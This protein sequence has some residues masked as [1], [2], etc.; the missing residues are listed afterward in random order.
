MHVCHR[1]RCVWLWIGSH[2]RAP[3]WDLFIP[4]SSLEEVWE[5]PIYILAG[6]DGISFVP[7][8]RQ[9]TL[10]ESNHRRA[11]SGPVIFSARTS[12]PF[13][14]S[15]ASEWGSERA[16]EG[17]REKGREGGEVNIQGTRGAADGVSP[18]RSLASN[19]KEQF[20]C[21]AEMLAAPSIPL[22]LRPNKSVLSFSWRCRQIKT[23]GRKAPMLVW[24][25]WV[26][27]LDLFC[28][29]WW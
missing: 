11:R 14:R 13:P 22:V 6:S 16:R 28:L 27:F 18:I 17:W 21:G 26:S 10:R 2:H 20:W 23:E 24:D 4:F 1:H 29:Q 3:K 9:A 8:K 12:A 7:F 19:G 15:P 5:M 25:G